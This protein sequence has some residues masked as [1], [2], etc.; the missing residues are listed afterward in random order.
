[1]DNEVLKII[2]YLTLLE[3]DIKTQ[4]SKEMVID[5]YRKLAQIYHP[6]VANSR[7]KDGKKFIE[8]QEAKDYL[9]NN[10]S[11]VN[12]LIRTGFSSATTNTKSSNDYAYEKWK[13][14]EDRL[15]KQREEEEKKRKETEEI[16]KKKVFSYEQAVSLFYKQRYNEAQ[17]L[18]EKLE[19]YLDSKIYLKKIENELSYDD[20]LKNIKEFSATN[21][22]T[23]LQNII[24]ISNELRIFKFKDSFDI[25]DKYKDVYESRKKKIGIKT[26]FLVTCA[27]LFIVFIA[28]LSMNVARE[29]KYNELKNLI[30]NYNNSSDVSRIEV[31]LDSLPDNYK[32]IDELRKE[33][34]EKF[35]NSYANLYSKLLTIISNYNQSD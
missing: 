26:S 17:K 28:I 8:L 25:Y 32:D 3:L 34:N 29:I 24:K 31:L 14:E 20:L 19:D 11:Y 10:M 16:E 22:F 30:R 35:D 21:S 5:A 4:I 7:Y 33:Y 13:Q 9:I 1:M 23:S 12:S 2:S 6:D 18:F 27:I 15:R